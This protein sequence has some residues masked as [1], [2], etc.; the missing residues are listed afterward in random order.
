MITQYDISK[1]LGVSQPNISLISTGARAV[2][3]RTALKLS[4]LFGQDWVFWKKADYDVIYS[5]FI[6]KY[7][8]RAGLKK[9]F[10]I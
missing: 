5:A 1:V 6:Q 7:S 2:P 4:K 8:D 3:K 9:S 10:K